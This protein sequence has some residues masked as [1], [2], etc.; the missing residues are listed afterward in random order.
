[1]FFSHNKS[2]SA[3]TT[4]DGVFVDSPRFSRQPGHGLSAKNFFADS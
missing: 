3:A 1:M 4:G 2:A